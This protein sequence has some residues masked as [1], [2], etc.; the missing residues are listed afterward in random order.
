MSAEAKALAR[1]I[2]LVVWLAGCGGPSFSTQGPE[3][4]AEAGDEAPV[5]TEGD[6]GSTG[7]DAESSPAASAGPDTGPDVAVLSLGAERR[8][9]QRVLGRT[10]QQPHRN[11]QAP[12]LSAHH[13]GFA[14]P[15]RTTPPRRRA[16]LFGLEFCTAV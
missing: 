15:L 9:A 6:A 5:V 7:R 4:L 2:A 12:R 8:G 3:Q 10:R 16:R 11:R 14:N 13:H 1:V